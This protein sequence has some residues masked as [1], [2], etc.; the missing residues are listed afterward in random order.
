MKYAIL[1]ASTALIAPLAL[2]AE[3]SVDYAPEFAETL[4]D[5]YGLKEGEYLAKEIREDI[6]RELRKAGIDVATIKVTILDAK[7]TKPT[8]EQLGAR[9]GLDYGRSVSLGGMEM[10]AEAFD[11]DGNMV[12]D[13]TYGWFENDLDQVGLSTWYDARRASNKFARKLAKKF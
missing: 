6:D 2:A 3:I 12:T 9:P 10:S 7:P 5:N 11:A 1:A 4:E 8:F 13:L